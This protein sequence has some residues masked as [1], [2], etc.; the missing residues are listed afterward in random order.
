MIGHLHTIHF[1]MKNSA[2][3]FV[4]L[5]HSFPHVCI[6]LCMKVKDRHNGNILLDAKGRVIH[7]DFGFILANSPG[8]NFRCEVL[9]DVDAFS[10]HRVCE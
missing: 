10:D 5:C 9:G 6:H 8:G 4:F 3:C 7:I 1:V 2:P